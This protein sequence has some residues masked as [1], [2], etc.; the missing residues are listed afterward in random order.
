VAIHTNQRMLSETS[1]HSSISEKPS[2]HA[3]VTSKGV[4]NCKKTL[5]N[6]IVPP[7]PGP[8]TVETVHRLRTDFVPKSHAPSPR[9]WEAITDIVRTLE[10]MA[11]GTAEPNVHLASL[12]PGVGKTQS[13]VQF[14]PVLLASKRHV[15]VSVIVCA[16]RLKQIEAVINDARSAGLREEDFAVFTSD[17]DLNRLG[18]G[19]EDRQNARVLFTTHAMVI[20]QCNEGGS[21]TDAEDFHYRR[22]PREV[23]VWDE[24]IT[25]GLAV[26]L[27]EIDIA[28]LIKPMAAQSTLFS[29]RLFDLA[30]DLRSRADGDQ[31]MVPDLG[32]ECGVDLNCLET[33]FSEAP[34]DQKFA[35][36]SLWFLLGKT[37]TVRRDGRFGNAMLDYRETLPQ[38]LA[39]LLVLDASSRRGM[40]ETYNLWEIQ[41]GGITR[42]LEAPKDYTPLT[43]HHWAVSG[44]KSAFKDTTKGARLVRGVA[45]TISSKPTEKW[46][47]VHH[48]DA[49]FETKVR[50]LLTADAAEIAFL[51][52]GAHDATN[53]YADVPN[54]ILAG[55]LFLRPSQYEAIGRAAAGLP[56]SAGAFPQEQFERVRRGEH[57]HMILQAIC[58]GRVR[59]CDG[60]R[61]PPSSVYIIASRGSHIGDDLPNIF[62]GCTVVPW[63]P[64]ETQLKGQVGDAV[65]VILDRTKTGGFVSDAEIM[66]HLGIKDSSNFR[67]TVKKHADFVRALD[68]QD[69]CPCKY[70][71]QSGFQR[72]VATFFEEIVEA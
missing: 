30:T 22:Q 23:R 31:F 41:V 14:L 64:V 27:S 3:P 21:F 11:D 47:V 60:S 10:Q 63:L 4:Q 20:K 62:P 46:L 37:V 53:D 39:P 9:M 24:A 25:R 5:S 18:R 49:E 17:R 51:N 68:E 58:R 57:R 61:C 8:L 67:R 71:R 52:W 1:I 12:D 40:R 29:N 13:V 59:K 6:G 35:A 65:A 72:R 34:E 66:Q 42:L 69:I 36:N 33:V 7:Q 2:V 45:N 19:I 26:T 55:T 70:S 38:G 44:G 54:V 15:D 28:S 43:I 32:T 50:M 56:S 16:G 48:K